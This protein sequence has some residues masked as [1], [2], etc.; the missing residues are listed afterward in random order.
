MGARRVQAKT[1]IPVSKFPQWIGFENL[2]FHSWCRRK[3]SQPREK[4]NS[5]LTNPTNSYAINRGMAG[6]R[7]FFLPSGFFCCCFSFHYIYGPACN[8]PVE[9]R[10]YLR[11]LYGKECETCDVSL[12]ISLYTCSFIRKN[13]GSYFP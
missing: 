1:K 7:R 4:E 6:H 2:W 13:H 11:M 9:G 12:F 3:I 10:K 8:A 5:R